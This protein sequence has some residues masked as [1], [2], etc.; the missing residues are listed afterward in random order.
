MTSVV[1]LK[2]WSPIIKVW[3]QLVA[4]VPDE[5]NE[6]EFQRDVKELYEQ[7]YNTGIDEALLK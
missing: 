1:F 7:A 4:N 3:R 5:Y 2:K 6:D